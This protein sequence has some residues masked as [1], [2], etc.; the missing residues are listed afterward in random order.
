MAN[1]IQLTQANGNPCLV[2]TGAVTHVI[3]PPAEGSPVGA[4]AIVYIGGQQL[5]VR[6]SVADIKGQL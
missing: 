2:N 1:V 5:A 4:R 3:T 6:E